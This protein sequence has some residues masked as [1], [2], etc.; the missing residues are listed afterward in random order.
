MN[1]I[2]A[3][4]QVPNDYTVASGRASRNPLTTNVKGPWRSSKTQ[5][6]SNAYLK[7]EGLVSLRDGSIKLHHPE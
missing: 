4:Y 1:S 3:L 5:A 6:L 7:S 2:P